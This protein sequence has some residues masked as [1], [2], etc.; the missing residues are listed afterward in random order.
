MNFVGH[1]GKI[2]SGGLVSEEEGDGEKGN[3]YF[4]FTFDTVCEIPYSY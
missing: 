1:L 2:E 3:A 4:V